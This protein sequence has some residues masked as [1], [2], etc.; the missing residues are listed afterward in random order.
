MRK[1]KIRALSV[2]GIALGLSLPYSTFS[3][4]EEFNCSTGEDYI[5]SEDLQIKEVRVRFHFMRDENGENNF[6]E[7][8]GELLISRLLNDQNIDIG[9]NYNLEHMPT[10]NWPHTFTPITDSRMR[11][12]L[13]PT[14]GDSQDPDGDGI[15]FHDVADYYNAPAEKGNIDI[16]YI[17]PTG[18]IINTVAIHYK[19]YVTNLDESVFNVFIVPYHPAYR[20]YILDNNLLFSTRGIAG[21]NPVIIGS[22]EKFLGLDTNPYQG[23]PYQVPDGSGGFIPDYFSDLNGHYG[24]FAKGT[25]NEIVHEICHTPLTKH[26]Y[27]NDGCDDT[28]ID[29][30][31]EQQTNNF[32][33]YGTE[34]SRTFSQCQLNKLHFGYESNPNLIEKLNTDFCTPSSNEMVITGTDV[35][36]NSIK[37][38]EGNIR[39]QNGAKLT[40]TC[41][42]YMSVNARIKVEKGGTLIVDDGKITK[43]CTE[44][45][46]PWRGIEVFGDENLSQ[47]P[48]SNQ[49]RVILKNG[50]VI[51]YARNGVSLIGHHPNGDYD[52]GTA[53]GV[54]TVNGAKFYNCFRAIEFMAYQNP[55]APFKNKSTITDCEVHIDHNINFQWQDPLPHGITLW[56]VDRVTIQNCNFRNEIT[57]VNA[58]GADKYDGVG[59]LTYDASVKIKGKY[60]GP[61][62]TNGGSKLESDYLRNY[63]YG[64]GHGIHASNWNE[65]SRVIIDR[66][67]FNQNSI[68]A[69][70]EKVS[71]MLFVR[72]SMDIPDGLQDVNIEAEFHPI[73]LFIDGITTDMEVEENN[74]LGN[75]NTWNPDGMNIGLLL[76]NSGSHDNYIYRNNFN[77]LVNPFVSDGVNQGTG[78]LQGINQG[79][80]LKCNDFGQNIDNYNDISFQGLIPQNEPN[81][82]GIDQFQGIPSSLGTLA[83]GNRFSYNPISSLFGHWTWSTLADNF[84]G[85]P[86]Q[87]YHWPDP[88]LTLAFDPYK[89]MDEY[90]ERINTG[91][92]QVNRDNY[93]PQDISIDKIDI[94]VSW[95]FEVYLSNLNNTIDQVRLELNTLENGY[96]N[97]L[98]G[99]IRP[100]IMDALLDPMEDSQDIRD[101]LVQGSPYLDDGVLIQCITRQPP[102]D[103]WHLTEA[104]VWN[105]PLTQNVIDALDAEMPLTEYLYSLVVAQDGSSQRLLYELDIKEEREELAELELEYLQILLEDDDAL[106]AEQKIIDLFTGVNTSRAQRFTISAYL[107]Q[108]K[109]RDAETILSNYLG[110]VNIEHYVAFKTLEIALMDAGENWFQMDATQLASIQAMADDKFKDGWQMAQGVLNLI[111]DATPV[112]EA[113]LIEAPNPP[114]SRLA[115]TNKPDFS[116]APKLLEIYPQ[117]A[118]SELYILADLPD[119]YGRATIRI[120]NVLG[121]VTDLIEI[122]SM[123]LKRIDVSRYTSGMYFAEFI[124]DGKLVESLPFNI[125]H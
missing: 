58:S 88:F 80:E 74:F 120:S 70:F 72:N 43:G 115:G 53:G 55:S 51:E 73:G 117:P 101:L 7:T 106:N 41:E 6:S 121:Q 29:P 77:K 1:I 66:T 14:N 89:S 124:V 35:I 50:A 45:L 112:P 62:V 75:L 85:N 33:D 30:I 17:Y 39:I 16:S 96:T 47:F 92:D 111:N 2:L 78:L 40:I 93:C 99:G 90:L 24:F 5:F 98:N 52:W 108:G 25:K 26:T 64:W 54:L 49:G 97:A 31:Y 59:I 4:T 87:Y 37:H 91:P 84:N 11:L 42:V 9:I 109:P 104:L 122:G 15:F 81:Y 23:D 38:I 86:Y 65:T 110:D 13:I 60:D 107:K 8:D 102:L 125:I 28:P 44:L 21:L 32:M 123:N 71:P 56:G 10:P 20:D 19:D 36:W 103:Q 100:E 105:G 61:P 94:I 113:I 27:E 18:T 12:V 34:Y 116:S 69:K 83:A 114:T 63:F 57:E 67:D 22:Y 82:N 119:N 48:Y 95:D 46:N 76:R 3:Q 79:F 118:N 68:A